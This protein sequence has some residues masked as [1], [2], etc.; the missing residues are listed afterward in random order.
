MFVRQITAMLMLA[1][2]LACE[3]REAGVA[4]GTLERERV[5]HIATANEVVESLPI[6]EGSFVEQGQILVELSKHRQQA[7][8]A[9]AKAQM[10]QAQ[11][12]LAKLRNGARAEEVAAAT[13]KVEGAKAS[14]RESQANFERESQL[15]KSKLN[16]EADYTKALAQR[17]A[18]QAELEAN[19][20][21]LKELTNGTRV[22]DLQAGEASLQAAQ[23]QLDYEQTLLEDLTIK[24]TRSGRLDNL[25]WNLG[26][27]VTIGSPVAIVLAD[28]APYA[29]VYV[30]ETYRAKV[31]VGDTMTV[32][33][34][35][36]QAPLQG[37][38]KWIATEPAF[39]PYYALNQEDR[40]R[41]MY[42]AEVQLGEDAADLPTGLPAQVKMP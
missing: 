12:Q 17:D 32:Y 27:R 41:L 9:L 40:A 24:A 26:E 6:N 35:G 7:K 16:S 20:Q 37:E 1:G 3:N 19:Q 28:T 5:A 2:L 36:I 22:E 38:V 23:A 39:T 18:N 15:Y 25:P 21:Q 13:A 31:N 14:L 33:V 29:R 8:V 4:L 30:P 34:D 10:F 42:L 11:A